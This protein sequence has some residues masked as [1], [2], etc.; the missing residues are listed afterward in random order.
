MAE[1][2]MAESWKQK[3]F[4][5]V[6]IPLPWLIGIVVA[7]FFNAGIVYKQFGDLQTQMTELSS[8]NKSVTSRLEA[9]DRRQDRVEDR[10]IAQALLIQ[11][12]EKR[13][14]EVERRR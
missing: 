5:G 6:E 8:F 14:R 10:G 7:L 13:L 1:S 3:L 9:A 2:N 4:V 12:H 11:D